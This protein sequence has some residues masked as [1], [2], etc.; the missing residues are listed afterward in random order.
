M[1]E[2]VKI[3]GSQILLLKAHENLVKCINICIANDGKHIENVT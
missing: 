1:V 3:E 2:C